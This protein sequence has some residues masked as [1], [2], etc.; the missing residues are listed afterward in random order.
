M[1]TDP[2]G[3]DPDAC[4]MMQVKQGFEPLNFTCHF[5]DWNPDLWKK[6]SSYESY[7]KS[8][9]GKKGNVSDVASVGLGDVCV[10]VCVCVHV[11]L[12]VCL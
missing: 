8:L 1:K 3:R 4:T 7:R 10:C 11:R 2:S 6:D 12:C 9:E 5:L